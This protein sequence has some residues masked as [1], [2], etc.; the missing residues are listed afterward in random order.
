M[1]PEF[2]RLLHNNDK[3]R[4]LFWLVHFEKIRIT[5]FVSK[6]HRGLKEGGWVGVGGGGVR[7]RDISV[8]RFT[9]PPSPGP[10]PPPSTLSPSS[11]CGRDN[12]ARCSDAARC[13]W[14]RDS[15]SGDVPQWASGMSLVSVT[16]FSFVCNGRCIQFKSGNKLHIKRYREVNIKRYRSQKWK[17]RIPQLSATPLGYKCANYPF[18]SLLFIDITFLN[19]VK[20][21]MDHTLLDTHF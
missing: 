9:H 15:V 2:M 10:H 19:E 5:K 14:R 8:S 17:V 6:D 18:L 20:I 3:F 12:P 4:W 21:I 16:T 7:S 11:P 13:R 1:T